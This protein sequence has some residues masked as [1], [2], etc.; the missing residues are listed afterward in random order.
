MLAMVRTAFNAGAQGMEAFQS[1]AKKTMEMTMG[2]ADIAQDE[3]KKAVG[4]W[5][6]NVEEARKAYIKSIEDGLSSLEQQFS[7]MG[8]SQKK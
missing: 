8:S 2:N 7:S 6:D 5:L 1:Q 3:A 4:A